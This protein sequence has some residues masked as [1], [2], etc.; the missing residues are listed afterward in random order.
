M[1]GIGFWELMFLALIALLVLGP[2]KLPSLA[3]TIGRWTGRARAL[4]DALKVQIERE[5][6]DAER[7]VDEDGTAGDRQDREP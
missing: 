6:A 2:E 4:A 1:F 3:S 7:A 5:V